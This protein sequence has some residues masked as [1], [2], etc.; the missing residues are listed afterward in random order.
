MTNHRSDEAL[1]RALEARVS[2]RARELEGL[3]RDEQSEVL[4]LLE[5]A[6]LLW[7][8]THAAPPLA[9]DPVAAMLGLVPDSA[10]TLD[11]AALQSVLKRRGL[12]ASTLGQKLVERGWAVST[13]NV[14]NW[15]AGRA[16]DV[17]PALIQAISEI[18]RTSPDQITKTSLLPS[19]PELEVAKAEPLFRGLVDRWARLTR[20]SLEWAAWDLESRM[21]A[22]VHRG[23]QPDAS[24]M[25][26]SLEVVV[27]ASEKRMR[28]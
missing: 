23:V 15:V 6:D 9:E 13:R 17:S 4:E 25:L 10:R 16:A 20:T 21:A 28:G 14:F 22:T 7:E 18:T 3:S 12:N 5:V 8:H 2:E 11:G 24:Q 1:D 19:Q 26:A 27:E